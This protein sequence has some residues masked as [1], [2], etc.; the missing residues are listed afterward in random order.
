[1]QIEFQNVLPRPLEAYNHSDESVWKRSFKIEL[2]KKIVL[3]ASSGKGKSTF[4]NTLYGVR[5]DY[6]GVIRINGEAIQDFD[7]DRWSQIRSTQLSVVFQDLQLFPDLTVWQ[8]LMLKNGLTNHKSENEITEMLT[9]LGIGDKKDQIAQ[10]LSYGQQQRVAIIR[11]LLQPFELLLMDEPFSHLDEGNTQLALEL[12][13]AET[14]ANGGGFIL[15]TLGSYHDYNF[16][17]ELKL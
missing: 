4:V 1:M 17:Q 10:T 8:N 15:T 14:N 11:A 5:H 3:N 2:P 12:I 16:D 13:T 7:M 9:H 6:S